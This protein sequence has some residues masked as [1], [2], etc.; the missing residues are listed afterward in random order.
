[1]LTD[2]ESSYLSIL[3][4][5]VVNQQILVLFLFAESL[6]ITH[7]SLVW[8]ASLCSSAVDIYGL[9]VLKRWSAGQL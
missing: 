2:A 5:F 1:M 4:H 6:S 7:I 3:D 9:C 8:P